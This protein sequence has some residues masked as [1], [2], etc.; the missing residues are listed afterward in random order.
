[1]ASLRRILVDYWPDVI[2]SFLTNV[3]V[4]AVVTVIGTYAVVIIFRVEL[5]LN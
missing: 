1:M 3:N 2:V 5:H 4:V